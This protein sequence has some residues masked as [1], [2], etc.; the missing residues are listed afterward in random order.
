MQK[1]LQPKLPKHIR[2]KMSNRF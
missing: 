1:R 2:T